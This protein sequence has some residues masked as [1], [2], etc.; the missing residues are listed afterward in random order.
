MSQL[1]D[2]IQEAR[3]AGKADD[4]I[5]QELSSQGWTNADITQAL[6]GAVS[7]APSIPPISPLPAVAAGGGVSAVAIGV[8]VLVVALLGGGVYYALNSSSDT[9]TLEPVA[10]TSA[11]VSASPRGGAAAYSC[12]DILTTSDVQRFTQDA[13]LV[14]VE[15]DDSSEGAIACTFTQTT[16][17][18][19]HS[20]LVIVSRNLGL[21]ASQFYDLTR[22]EFIRNVEVARAQGVNTSGVEVKDVSGIGS[23][24][25]STVLGLS[26]TIG[27]LST[28]GQ[29]Y[30]SVGTFS[31]TAA[32]NIQDIAKL[33]DA[34]I[35]KF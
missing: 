34:N 1:S 8:G 11:V 16:D 30:F 17:L 26:P 31:D 14:D 9:S 2:F 15:F 33:V 3:S 28:N 24:A 29:A 23:K 10:S 22:S 5:S 27:V 4:V 20:I 21:P 7:P 25:F 12:A 13:S 35:S 19:A 32:A 18:T 6:G